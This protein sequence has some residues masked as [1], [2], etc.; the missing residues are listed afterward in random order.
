MKIIYAE[1][2][3]CNQFWIYSNYIA[4]CLEK[5]QKMVVWIPD[6]TLPYFPHFYNSDFIYFPFY[7]KMILKM[8]DYGKY[9]RIIRRILL[10]RISLPASRIIFSTIFRIK[11]EVVHTESFEKS[12]FVKK[13]LSKI[14]D[15]FQPPL[16]ITDELDQI[17][18]KIRQK[19]SIIIGLHIRHGDYQEW[20]EGK[21][22]YSIQ[23]YHSVMLKLTKMFPDQEVA[24]FIASN[25][26]ISLSSFADLNCYKIGNGSSVKDLYGLGCCDYIT[27]PPSTFSAWASLYGHVP[28][29]HIEDMK[30]DISFTSFSHIENIWL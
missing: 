19:N 26:N 3:T 8:F 30:D 12:E 6:I 2:Q 10:N 20:R 17:F 24:F 4:D 25:E 7:S 23:E 16:L 9:L 15:I 29:Y 13:H 21:Y 27:G 1:G 14:R 28:I 18:D 5:K 11:F 22:F